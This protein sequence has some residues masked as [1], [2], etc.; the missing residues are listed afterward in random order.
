MHL[1]QGMNIVEC[2]SYGLCITMISIM[3]QLRQ[4]SVDQF[5]CMGPKTKN[6]LQLGQIFDMI[7][8]QSHIFCFQTEP[9]GTNNYT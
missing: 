3:Y 1:T 5:Q 9:T 2:E 7:V 4:V 6:H 8:T